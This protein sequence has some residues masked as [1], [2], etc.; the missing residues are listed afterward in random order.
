MIRVEDDLFGGYVVTLSDGE[1]VSSSFNVCDPLNELP[2]L[3]AYHRERTA[4]YRYMRLPGEEAPD[5]N[6]QPRRAVGGGSVRREQASARKNAESP[7][8]FGRMGVDDDPSRAAGSERRG[9]G[10]PPASNTGGKV[11]W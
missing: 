6:P 1:F 8:L 11:A 2:G 4:P 3:L 9:V 7:S 10:K 5:L